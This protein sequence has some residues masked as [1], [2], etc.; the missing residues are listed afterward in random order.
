VAA[1]AGIATQTI[2]IAARRAPFTESVALVAPGHG[3]VCTPTEVRVEVPIARLQSRSLADKP[4]TIVA[5]S[6]GDVAV[7]VRPAR[8]S[9]TLSGPEPRLQALDPQEITVVLDVSA[10]LPGRYPALPLVPQLPGWAR[11]DSLHPAT[12]DVTIH[13]RTR[14]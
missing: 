7:D 3:I 1:L 11:L 8:A 10:L 6:A 12:V 4:L 5:P 9:V 2:E 13:R 14:R